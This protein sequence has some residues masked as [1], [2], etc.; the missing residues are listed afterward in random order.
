MRD[1]ICTRNYTDQFPTFTT[2]LV[3]QVIS[4]ARI[5]RGPYMRRVAVFPSSRLETRSYMPAP[6]GTDRL[7]LGLNISRTWSSGMS[8]TP[9]RPRAWR[10]RWRSLSDNS[11]RSCRLRI[12][13]GVR[14]TSRLVFWPAC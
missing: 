1:L 11:R 14:K 7:K 5:W 12:T 4:I 6:G 9:L 3:T 13:C 8:R 10:K 2:I